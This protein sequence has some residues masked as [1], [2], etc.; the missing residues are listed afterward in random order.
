MRF[1]TAVVAIVLSVAA[2]AGCSP[3]P[4]PPAAP[5]SSGVTAAEAKSI[6]QDG[7]VFGLPVV[8]I[9]L[10]ADVQ[11]NVPKPEGG[12]APFNQ[13]DHHR[14]FPDA[15][16]NKIVGMNVD[17]LYSLANLDLTA[18][19]VVLVVPPMAGKRWW[20][21]QI[22]DAWND[23]P[24][25]P[26]SRTHDGKGGDFAIVGPNFKGEIPAGLEVIHCDTSI[27]A[28]GGRTYTAGPRD[29]AAVHKIQDQYQLIP[30]SQWKGQGTRYTP[31]A[32]VPVKPGVD[33]SASVPAQVFKMS[34]EEYFGRLCDL[35]VNN[36]A[37][38]ADA[39]IMERLAKLGIK[40]GA[41]FKMDAFDADTRKA[42]EE[43]VA[44]GQQEI[45]DGESQMGEM[46]NGW[47]IARDL[48]RYGTR[49]A[50]RA[51]WTFFGVGGNVVEDALYPFGLVD[52]D[53]KKFDGANKYVLHLTKDEIPPVDAFW[54]LTL[55][56]KDSYLVD[57]P[58][59]RY[60]LG[61]RSNLKFG[62]D[63]SLTLYIQSESP[64]KDKERNWLPAPK[65]GTFKLALRLYIPKQQVADGTW[66]PPA[67]QRVGS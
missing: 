31:P 62:P 36:P 15:K 35:L 2:L 41:T 49:Y 28:L 56:D 48:G 16:N 32:E 60:A 59:N 64:G 39:P 26:G 40:P 4:A 10:Q 12:R 14:E 65:Q 47:Q 67:V 38:E 34:A 50:Y 25:A 3:Q 27:C 22:I 6:A 52:A 24:A 61:D 44:A 66:K 63:G 8:Y 20:I 1:G 23:V 43:G 46:V 13:F 54:S 5:S 9:A 58:L 17:T 30:L 33:A 55:Y 29:Y 37:R 7:Y 42:I 53:G 19:P 51:T 11:T 45:R 18:E 57:N 21:M